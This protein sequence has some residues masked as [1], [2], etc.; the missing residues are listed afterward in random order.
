MLRAARWSVTGPS[1][2]LT[3]ANDG[4]QGTAPGTIT[5][6]FGQTVAG[7]VTA[8]I[9]RVQPG[10]SR[11]LTLQVNI[12]ANLNADTLQNTADF[13]YDPGTGTPVGPFPPNTTDFSVVQGA[14]VTITGATVPTAPQRSSVV[15]T[16]PVTNTGNGSDSFDMTVTNGTF[17]AGTTFQLFKSDGSTPLVD[18]NGNSMPDTGTI[19]KNGVYNIVV[20]AILPPGFSGTGVNYTAAVTATSHVDGSV[21]ANANDVLTSVAGNTVDLTNTRSISGGATSADGLGA[22]PEV[23]PVVT[24]ATK[25]STT[26]RFT[27]YVNN[28]TAAS[29]TFNLAASFGSITLPVGWSMIFKD[30][31]GAVITNT[32]SSQR[33]A[34]R[35]FMPT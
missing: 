1:V 10:A 13:S 31:S 26:T 16:N 9:S 18:T 19:A 21:S 2:T 12:A 20:K 15:F 4:A 24:N 32:A 27:L 33:T 8:V 23:T 3:D 34:A 6:D 28:T 14:G 30:A 35:L 29:D 25:P 17:P 11:T 22:G 7:R 5:Y